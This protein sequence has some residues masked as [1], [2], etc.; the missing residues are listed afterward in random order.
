MMMIQSFMNLWSVTILNK[1]SISL[2]KEGKLMGDRECPNCCE[3]TLIE[4]GL[5][6]WKC[7]KCGEVFDEKWLDEAEDMAYERRL[8]E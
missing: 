3:D 4:D 1:G 6:K 5:S 8:R 2:G 7:L